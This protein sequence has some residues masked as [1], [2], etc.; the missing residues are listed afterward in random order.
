[1]ETVKYALDLND[2]HDE[3]SGRLYTE[4]FQEDT[5]IFEVYAEPEVRVKLMQ[6]EAAMAIL[7]QRMCPMHFRISGSHT[8]N[9]IKA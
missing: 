3:L 7:C 4:K 6:V 1:M 2:P 9:Y 8:K 5:N